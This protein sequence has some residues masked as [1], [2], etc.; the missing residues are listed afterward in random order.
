MRVRQYMW[1]SAEGRCNVCWFFSESMILVFLPCFQLPN[2]TKRKFDTIE[3]LWLLYIKKF[4]S[5]HEKSTPQLWTGRGS[6]T[7]WRWRKGLFTTV[8]FQPMQTVAILEINSKTPM[9]FDRRT[10][11]SLLVVFEFSHWMSIVCLAGI[12]LTDQLAFF[13]LFWVAYVH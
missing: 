5:W 12:V 4:W 1:F 10:I 3:Y 9:D 7:N 11:R 2:W 6:F 13:P 8:K